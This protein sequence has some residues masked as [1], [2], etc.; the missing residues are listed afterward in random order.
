MLNKPIRI[1]SISLVKMVKKF[2]VLPVIFGLLFLVAVWKIITKIIG[3]L[4]LKLG[5]TSTWSKSSKQF[6]L[7]AIPYSH[8]CEKARLALDLCKV[9]YVEH[10]HPPVLHMFSSL[11]NSSG[12]E[13]STPLLVN[14][15][16]ELLQDSGDILKLLNDSGNS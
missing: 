13:T 2:L 6:H 12:K 4:N 15:K 9:D 14:D 10:D 5:I 11:Y 8:F 3:G 1:G 7:H 16:K